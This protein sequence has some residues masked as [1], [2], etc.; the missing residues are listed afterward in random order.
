M[1]KVAL[2]LTE[3]VTEYRRMSAEE[4]ARRISEILGKVVLEESKPNRAA[5]RL[6]IEA[7]VIE[8]SRRVRG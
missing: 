4:I 8:L 2:N 1:A 7:G 3:I 5:I 6:E